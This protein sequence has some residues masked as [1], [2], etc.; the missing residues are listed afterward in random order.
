VISQT[1]RS[2]YCK[3]E[4]KGQEFA[5]SANNDVSIIA[6]Y[7]GDKLKLEV[8]NNTTETIFLFSSYFEKD[9]STS[10]YIY[11]YDDKKNEA[12]I[13]FLP[14]IPYMYTK[15]SDNIIMEDRILKEYQTV[16]DFYKI[17]PQN[18]YIFYVDIVD[19]KSKNNYIKDI[20]V[21]SLNK[22]E[23][24]KRIRLPNKVE[25]YTELAYYKDVSLLCNRDAYFLKELDFNKQAKE[26]K[27]I[28]V[29]IVNFSE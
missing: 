24:I 18:K 20:D 21:D 3:C 25:Y 19:L 11:R 1:E 17:L 12:K 7:E 9:I 16:Y 10:K 28:K 13:S 23:K 14:L 2:T 29:P 8:C 22:F 26:Y 6:N 5:K 15:Y 4:I 27:R